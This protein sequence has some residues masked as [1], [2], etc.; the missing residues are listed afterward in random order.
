M[1]VAGPAL[2]LEEGYADG[3]DSLAWL[4]LVAASGCRYR[5]SVEKQQAAELLLTAVGPHGQPTCQ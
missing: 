5:F 2:A 4:P 3:S 1:T